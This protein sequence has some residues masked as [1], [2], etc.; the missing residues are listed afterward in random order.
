MTKRNIYDYEV[1]SKMSLTQLKQILKDN[2]EKH[3]YLLEKASKH[4][5][6]NF[7]PTM[8]QY[9]ALQAL[10]DDKTTQI[11]FGGG[12]G[13]AKSILG[14]FWIISM[15]LAYSGTAW[16]IGRKTMVSL[17]QTTLVSFFEVMKLLNIPT[18]QY[19]F[20]GQ[21]NVVTFKNGSVVY[22][23]DMDWKPSDPHYTRF[24]GLLL[25]GAFLDEANEI[26]E[27]AIEIINSRIGRM[28]NDEYN[29]LPKMLY[30]FNPDKGFVYRTF[31]EPWKKGLEK[32]GHKYIPALAIDNPHIA[33]SYIDT[34]WNLPEISK[35]RLLFGNFDYDDSDD[36]LVDY[37]QITALFTTIAKEI[38]PYYIIVDIAGDGKDNSVFSVWRGGE[39]FVLE[40]RNG[41][42]TQEVIEHIRK[43]ADEYKVPNSNIAVDAIGIGEGVAHSPLLS[44]CVP[45]KSSNVP[46]PTK[47]EPVSKYDIYGNKRM[48]EKFVT[49]NYT[50]LRSQMGWV[51]ASKIKNGELA[52]RINE[53]EQVTV[54]DR[55][56]TMRDVIE[57]ELSMLRD[58]NPDNDGV[59]KRLMSKKDMKK[60]LGRSP[61]VLDI[62]LMRQ[63]FEVVKDYEIVYNKKSKPLY[64]RLFW[65]KHHKK[66]FK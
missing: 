32:A 51:L 31:Y 30:A 18:K 13:G 62:F 45:F 11:G 15:A 43:L 27:K 44:G 19:K 56:M 23:K 38:E 2:K 26:P 21:D 39:L 35:Q 61:D 3:K 8:R 52:I 34:L 48:E 28:K 4:K 55:Q 17:K 20:N 63:Y 6:S 64:E 16:F 10:Q 33:E 41:M 5:G 36:M 9:E 66:K 24:G 37:Q 47:P 58:G 29:L 50:N 14:V 46:V 40:L 54:G 42:N 53:A 49:P 1:I 57:E 25:T 22:L 7:I 59:K 12:A 60:F 65:K